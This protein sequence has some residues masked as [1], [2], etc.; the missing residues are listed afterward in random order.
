MKTDF[1]FVYKN[2]NGSE[3]NS[4]LADL[5]VVAEGPV[6]LGNGWI[7]DRVN[8]DRSNGCLIEFRTGQ[9]RVPGIDDNCACEVDESYVIFHYGVSKESIDGLKR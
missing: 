1:G 2:L 8:F 6:D 5:T 9:E 4:S 7:G 3:A